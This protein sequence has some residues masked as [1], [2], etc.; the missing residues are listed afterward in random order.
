MSSSFA[1]NRIRLTVAT[2]AIGA[3]VTAFGA[4]AQAAPL[5]LEQPSP[6]APVATTTGSSAFGVNWDTGMI[7]A[8]AV[9]PAAIV[10]VILCSIGLSTGSVK[11]T[12][13]NDNPCLPI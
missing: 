4:T 2:L 9:A 12:P 3:T 13:G 7:T 5:P 10:A 6:A 8:S 1:R 11:E